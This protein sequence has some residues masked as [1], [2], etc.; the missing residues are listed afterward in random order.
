M[1]FMMFLFFILAHVNANTAYQGM[2]LHATSAHGTPG[3]PHFQSLDVLET[4]P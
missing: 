2:H 4:N 1:Q 3:H